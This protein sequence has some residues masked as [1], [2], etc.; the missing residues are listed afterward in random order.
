MLSVHDSKLVNSVRG[1]LS[2][3]NLIGPSDCPENGSNS[4]TPLVMRAVNG[5]E[6]QFGWRRRYSPNFAA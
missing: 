1:I 3:P 4:T 5:P 6:C 2:A